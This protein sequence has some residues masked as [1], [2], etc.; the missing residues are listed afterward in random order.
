M[1]ESTVAVRWFDEGKEPKAA[2][3]D[4]WAVAFAVVVVGVTMTLVFR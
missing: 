1:L 4:R 3:L 2:L